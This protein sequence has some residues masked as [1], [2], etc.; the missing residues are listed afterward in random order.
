ML[1]WGGR[2]LGWSL[3]RIAAAQEASWVAPPGQRAG[4][5]AGKWTAAAV[6]RICRRHGIPTDRP[7]NP[8]GGFLTQVR[9]RVRRA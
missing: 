3:R 6:Q 1:I 4:Y 9:R 5:K 2:I 7:E 8:P